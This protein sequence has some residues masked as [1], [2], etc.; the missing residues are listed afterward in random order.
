MEIKQDLAGQ[1]LKIIL[2]K[3]EKI[4]KLLIEIKEENEKC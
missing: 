3:L 1:F 2:E 4:E